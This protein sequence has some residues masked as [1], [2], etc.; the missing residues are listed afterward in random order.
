M[1]QISFELPSGE[2][3]TVGFTAGDSVMRTAVAND[4]D[5]IIGECGGELNCGTCHVYVE[6]PNV[7]IP[8]PT[9]D[10]SDMLEVVDNVNECSRLSCQISL[11]NDLDGL[12][13][14]VPE[15]S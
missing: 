12:H 15:E 9:H 2:T 13:V 14:R 5:G 10:E 3:R 1:N 4:I 11:T 7:S 8:S 6:T